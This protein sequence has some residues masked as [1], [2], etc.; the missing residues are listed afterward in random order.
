MNQKG[1]CFWDLENLNFIA[2]SLSV[3]NNCTLVKGNF[4]V[5]FN[6]SGYYGKSDLRFNSD[7]QR[8]SQIENIWLVWKQSCSVT[9][10]MTSS[11]T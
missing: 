2:N 9:N 7:I 10:Y 1:N 6:L 11:E 8:F 4:S 3:T 5:S